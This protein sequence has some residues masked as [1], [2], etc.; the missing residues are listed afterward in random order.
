MQPRQAPAS[1]TRAAARVVAI[2]LGERPRGGGSVVKIGWGALLG[3][4]ALVLASLPRAATATVHGPDVAEV[5]EYNP[6]NGKVFY[7]VHLVLD[8]S[9][10][11][12]GERVSFAWHRAPACW[13]GGRSWT[14]PH[15]VTADLRAEEPQGGAHP[16]LERG[17][18]Q[19]LAEL[20][21]APRLGGAEAEMGEAGEDVPG[22][23]LGSGTRTGLGRHAPRLLSLGGHEPGPERALRLVLIVAS[24][25]Q[26][27]V[28]HRRAATGRHRDHVIE[29]ERRA[30]RAAGPGL[31]DG[32]ALALIALP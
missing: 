7:L 17:D 31:A 19:G 22:L 1:S 10:F 3:A 25:L 8:S 28:V 26:A 12:V 21:G 2:R 14:R 20:S 30:R 23:V 4:I 24:T 18:G 29:F 11:A 16:L 9:H 13:S 15:V 5:L 32:G 6:M 27:N